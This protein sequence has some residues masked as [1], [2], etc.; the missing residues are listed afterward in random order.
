MNLIRLIAAAA[1]ALALPA[2]PSQAG[3]PIQ[4]GEPAPDFR[5]KAAHGKVLSLA[6]LQGE[7]ATLLIF[8]RG[9]W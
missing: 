1:L 3:D 8:F 4:V 9:L 2:L 6:D 7:K 5:L